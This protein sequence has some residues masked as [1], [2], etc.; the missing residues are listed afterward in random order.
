MKYQLF[1]EDNEYDEFQMA[2]QGDSFYSAL[3]EINELAFKEFNDGDV[4]VKPV[5]EKILDIIREH[6]PMFTEVE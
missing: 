5:A 4:N 3:F 2:L 1:F 6:A